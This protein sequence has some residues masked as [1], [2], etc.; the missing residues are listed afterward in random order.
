[1]PRKTPSGFIMGNILKMSFSLS[2]TATLCLET[3]KSMRPWTRVVHLDVEECSEELLRQQSYAIKN[4]VG[5]VLYGIR[6]LAQAS[7]G[8]LSTNKSRAST[9]LD[10]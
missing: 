7:L 8:K 6:L 3:R 9:F 2:W 4:H 5:L 1:M 10:Q